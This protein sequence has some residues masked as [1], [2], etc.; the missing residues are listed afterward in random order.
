MVKIIDIIFNH[1]FQ[2]IS[3]LSSA[4]D[5]SDT[6]NYFLKLSN[7]RDLI[8]KQ[9]FDHFDKEIPYIIFS[10]ENI[11]DTTLIIFKNFLE[12]FIDIRFIIPKIMYDCYVD[13]IGIPTIKIFIK[14]DNIPDINTTLRLKYNFIFLISDNDFGY[15]Y[16]DNSVIPNNE[17]KILYDFLEELKII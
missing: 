15:I 17:V 6:L 13:K 7:R 5:L 12:T 3:L 4:I 2:N 1:D 8:I 14:K 9:D 11:Q 10:T 16:L